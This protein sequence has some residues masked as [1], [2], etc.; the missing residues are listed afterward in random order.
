M[1]DRT[2]EGEPSL[3]CF[4]VLAGSDGPAAN[5][6]AMR[7]LTAEEIM[8]E[9]GPE[10]SPA[11]RAHTERV[12]ETA[13]ALAARYGSDPHAARIAGLLHDWARETTHEALLAEAQV[14]GVAVDAIEAREPMLLHGKIA[15]ARAVERFGLTDP[16]LLAALAH[17]I[18]GAPGMTRLAQV[19]FLADF[20]EPGRPYPAA[21]KA[22]EAARR[23]LGEA[24]LLT[25]NAIIIHVVTQ[26]Y[27]LHP[28]TLEARNELLLS[29]TEPGV[30]LE[31]GS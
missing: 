29:M 7:N 20:I 16:E 26:G 4:P 10:L 6:G 2:G 5:M 21:A 18:T 15:A 31:E 17:H 30:R 3:Y 13:A 22:R 1:T 11:R 27:L 8:T 25:Y 14:R 28:R 23:G 24:L 9:I 19:V 12:A